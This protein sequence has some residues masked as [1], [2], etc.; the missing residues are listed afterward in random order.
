MSF[1]V[2]QKVICIDGSR[3]PGRGA[4]FETYPKEGEVYTISGFG[5]SD[6][7]CR[8]YLAEIN[9]PP[10]NY[11]SGFHPATWATIRFRPLVQK[12]TS[13]A[14]FQALLNPNNEEVVG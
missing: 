12:K 6:K 7:H 2:G 10:H 14:I 5:P 3:W 13:I 4:G 1:R 11:I 8:I 9:N